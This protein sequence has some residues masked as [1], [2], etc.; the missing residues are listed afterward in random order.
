MPG[1]T[2]SST[3]AAN[4]PAPPLAQS[5]WAARPAR[6]APACQPAKRPRARI[7]GSEGASGC[8]RRFESAAHS[9]AV[10]DLER[11]AAWGSF[12]PSS[13]MASGSTGSDFTLCCSCSA[14]LLGG[15]TTA[16]EG[17]TSISPLW[18]A[19][20]PAAPGAP[21]ALF[22]GLLGADRGLSRGLCRFAWVTG[23]GTGA[24]AGAGAGGSSGTTSEWRSRL[25]G[26]S[27]V[28]FLLR[29]AFTLGVN[30]VR[31]T[32]PRVF[33]CEPD[34]A[35]PFLSRVLGRALQIKRQKVQYRL[36]RP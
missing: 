8:I 31:C 32:P 19:L 18:A 2:A 17:S 12:A 3:R 30:C 34:M 1:A 15:R 4:R 11:D 6:L 28:S 26:S 10:S 13:S 36:F 5:A 24:A 9:H 21:R 33:F 14:K 16:A 29:R 27:S 23:F 22:D 35:V 25:N 7:R 20:L